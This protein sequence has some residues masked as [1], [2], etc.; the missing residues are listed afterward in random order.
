M[1]VVVVVAAGGG[2]G[3]GV[4]GLVSDVGDVGGDHGCDWGWAEIDESTNTCGGSFR[5]VFGNHLK[6]SKYKDV[7]RTAVEMMGIV[8]ITLPKWPK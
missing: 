1:V 5:Y 4:V 3:A 2:G 8:R 7:T 6:R